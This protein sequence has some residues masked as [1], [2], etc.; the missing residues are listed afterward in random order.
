MRAIALGAV[1]MAATLVVLMIG[2]VVISFFPA[3]TLLSEAFFWGYALTGGLVLA[4]GAAVAGALAAGRLP[5]GPVRP[6]LAPVGP[7]AVVSLVA[8]PALFGEDWAAGVLYLALT[9]AG[10]LAGAFGS[11]RYGARGG[12]P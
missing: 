2:V 9:L 1:V 5:S 7:L 12:R 11:A 10:S 8:V 4:L 6:L 3:D